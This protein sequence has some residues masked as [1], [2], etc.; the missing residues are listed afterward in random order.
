MNKERK[1]SA[2]RIQALR[3][4]KELTQEAFAQL[5]GVSLSTVQKW[6]SGRAVPRTHALKKAIERVR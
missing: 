5:L 3:A 4:R 1:E 6:E 2:Q